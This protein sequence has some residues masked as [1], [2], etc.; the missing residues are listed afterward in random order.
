M[1]AN[2]WGH[3]VRTTSVRF[4]CQAY[5]SQRADSLWALFSYRQTLMLRANVDKHTGQPRLLSREPAASATGKKCGR[6]VYQSERE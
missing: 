5:R 6:K 2:S 4:C 1:C 3:I